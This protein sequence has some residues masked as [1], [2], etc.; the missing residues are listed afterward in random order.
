MIRRMM[1]IMIAIYIYS[2][3]ISGTPT[4]DKPSFK[5]WAF[6]L[7]GYFGGMKIIKKYT[8]RK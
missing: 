3:E 4:Y 7:K 2:L 6:L 5:D 8:L 1:F